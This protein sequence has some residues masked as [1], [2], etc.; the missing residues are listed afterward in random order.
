MRLWKRTGSRRWAEEMEITSE[1]SNT[2][3]I[4]DVLILKTRDIILV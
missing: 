2:V 3:G 1:P 4:G